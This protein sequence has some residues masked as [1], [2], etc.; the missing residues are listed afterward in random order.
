MAALHQGWVKPGF[1]TA[2]VGV[3]ACLSKVVAKKVQLDSKVLSELQ[4]LPKLI[5]SLH[6]SDL[7]GASDL[8]PKLLEVKAGITREIQNRCPK[9]FEMWQ[10]ITAWVNCTKNLENFDIMAILP[11]CVGDADFVLVGP[12]VL[13]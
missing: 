12:W 7:E 2:C 6:G 11:S 1:I 10:Q 8:S 13:I 5:R 9:Y 4:A 3:L